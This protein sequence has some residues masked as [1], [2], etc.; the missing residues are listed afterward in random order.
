MDLESIMKL[1]QSVSDSSLSSF[2]LE[3]G[4]LRLSLTKGIEAGVV[5]V[6]RRA[7]GENVQSVAGEMTQTIMETVPAAAAVEPAASAEPAEGKIIS[8][9]LVGT[10]YAASSPD[11]EN[12]V[13]LGDT[14]K[15]G[16]ILGIV[17]AMKLMNEIE[18]DFDGVVKAIYVEDGQMVEYGQPMFLIG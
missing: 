3:E 15:K 10:F 7:A 5:S 8:S 13:A 17:E 16:K 18:S 11:A 9:P 4:N 12:Y 14:V 2:T 6:E 1:I